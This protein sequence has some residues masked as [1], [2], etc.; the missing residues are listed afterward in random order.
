[1]TYKLWLK[2]C[3]HK[4]STKNLQIKQSLDNPL[5]EADVQETWLNAILFAIS[6]AISFAMLFAILFSIPMRY[7][8]MSFAIS[9]TMLLRIKLYDDNHKSRRSSDLANEHL[10]IFFFVRPKMNIQNLFEFKLDKSTKSLHWRVFNYGTRIKF[11]EHIPG[12]LLLF[13]K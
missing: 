3:N 13:A 9:F 12:I 11:S 5:R 4:G 7:Q 10:N 1:M 6:F 2:T 8:A